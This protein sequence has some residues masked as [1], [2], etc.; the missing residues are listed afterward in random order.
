V[1]WR[2]G[3]TRSIEESVRDLLEIFHDSK[4]QIYSL[5]AYCN[6]V[7]QR[8]EVILQSESDFWYLSKYSLRNAEPLTST[9]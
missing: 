6:D 8:C 4:T 3:L 2:G 7:A 9:A 5:D 1:Q